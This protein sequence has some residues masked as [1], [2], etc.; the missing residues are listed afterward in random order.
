MA[1]SDGYAKYN[2]AVAFDGSHYLVVWEEL[3]GGN[4]RDIKAQRLDS[5]GN[6]VGTIFTV[7]SGKTLQYYPD[8][9]HGGGQFLVVWRD[10]TSGGNQ[11][12]RIKFAAP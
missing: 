6:K 1:L 5:N 9:A 11:A 8:V 12:A 10:G 7:A 4:D 2:P 3:L